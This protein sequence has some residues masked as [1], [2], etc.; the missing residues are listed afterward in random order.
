MKKGFTLMEVLAVLLIIAVVAS[1]T[2]PLLRKVNYQVK[3]SQAKT[4]ALKLAE[5]L[6]SYYQTNRGYSIE[7][8]AFFNPTDPSDLSRI[9]MAPASACSSPVATGIPSTAAGTQ[10]IEQL[11]A[12]GYLSFKD[13][14]GIPYIFSVGSVGR[15]ITPPTSNAG[16][17]TTDANFIPLSRNIDAVF[18][19]GSEDA[20]S[21]F[22][23]KVASN[24]YIYVDGTL[25]PKDTYQ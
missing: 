7:P 12:C 19:V 1:M 21:R 14:K 22:E 5:A 6:R 9:V 4:A 2:V 3:N 24:N 8:G 20:G 13:F 25:K 15:S 17:P 10:G 11:F 23:F 18:A 16:Y